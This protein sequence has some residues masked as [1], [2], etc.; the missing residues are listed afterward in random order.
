MR[1]H[2]VEAVA[3]A[4]LLTD[5]KCADGGAVA[6]EEV[7]ASGLDGWVEQVQERVLEIETKRPQIAERK[8]GSVGKSRKQDIIG[9]EEAGAVADGVLTHTHTHTHTHIHTHTRIFQGFF[10][11]RC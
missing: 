7:L 2:H 5:R 9:G 1:P 10:S 4:V 3:W 8:R 11:D 6:C